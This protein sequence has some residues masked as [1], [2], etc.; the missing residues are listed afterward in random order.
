MSTGLEKFNVAGR[1]ACIT[2]ASSGLGRQC[3]DALAAAGAAV[4]GVARREDML[5]E[6]AASGV[7]ERAYGASKGGVAQMTR[8]MA[9][10]WSADGINANAIGPGFFPTELTAA[11]FADDARAE[12]NAAQTCVGRNGRLED[13]DGPLLFLCSP[14]ADYVTG[15]ILMVDGGFTAK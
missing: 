6:W 8:A 15:Q 5:A 13:I 2:G 14:A 7:G 1:V 10:A 12:R 4:V 11:V 3:A 9:E